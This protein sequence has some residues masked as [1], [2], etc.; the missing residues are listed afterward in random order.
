MKQIS[1]DDYRLMVDVLE[2]YTRGE[3]PSE[4]RA[5]NIHRRAKKLLKRLK[6]K[7]R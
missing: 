5:F 3:P 4:L 1:N 6:N 7:T 2:Q